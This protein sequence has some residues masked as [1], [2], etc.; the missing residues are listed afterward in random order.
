MCKTSSL[1]MYLQCHHYDRLR[2]HGSSHRVGQDWGHHLRLYR[3]SSLHP[4]LH[5]HGQG[6][7][8]VSEVDL[9]KSLQ[10]KIVKDIVTFEHEK[11]YVTRFST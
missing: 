9:H 5:K 6:L 3:H 8:K 7:L 4:L 10:V 2:P 11:F 1:I